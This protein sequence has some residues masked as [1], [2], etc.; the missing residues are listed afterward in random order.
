M[1]NLEVELVARD[2][3]VWSGDATQVSAPA[4]EGEV[5]I[6]VGHQPLLAVL[7]PGTVR[8]FGLD[9]SVLE[10]K[11]DAG[12]ISVDDDQVTVVVD[13]AEVLGGSRR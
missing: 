4:A 8:I 3:T 12:F 10:A 9:R 7:K 1:A 11:V 13:S 5:G 2:R 6:L